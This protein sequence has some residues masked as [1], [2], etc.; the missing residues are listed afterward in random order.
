MPVVEEL[1]D[2]LAG[3]KFFTKLDLRSGYHQIRMAEKDEAKTAFKSHSGHFEFRVMPFGLTC[4]PAT[5]QAAMNSI[6][7]HV[8]RKFVLVF[9]DDILIYSRTLAD[10]IHHLDQVFN[11]LLQNQL[12]VK[13]NKCSFAQPSLEYLGHIIGA[14]GVS[15]DPA[16]IDAVQQW[17]TPLNVKQLRGFLGLAGYYRRFIRNFG[18]I[19]RP[20]TTLLKKNVPYIWTSI[21]DEAFSALKHAL[22]QAPVLAL[23]DFTKEFVL[24]TDACAYGM[25]AVLM[26]Q[27]HP[28]AFLSRALGPKNQ[29]LSTYDKEC[30]AIL[31]GI[32]KW[33]SYLQHRPFTILTDQKS[34]VQLGDHRFNTAMQQKAFFRL[35]GLRYKI[36][37]KKGITNKAA[38][39]LSRRSAL[40]HIHAMSTVQPRWVEIIMEGYQQDPHAKQL[41][42]ELAIQSP[43]NQGFSLTDGI[44][45]F[46]GRIWLGIH[47]AAHQ[48]VLLALHSSGLGG[49]SGV[50]ATYH[51]V[52]QLFAWP[53]LKQDVQNFVQHCRLCQQAKSD[54][55]RTPGLL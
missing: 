39:A 50:L 18:I 47:K 19:C 26:Q 48:A 14:D 10:H 30:V 15:T 11:L 17:P 7:A 41:L 44:I 23:L 1:M 38:D 40:L 35:M 46:H 45:R 27:G 2:E 24:E 31:L 33:K 21:E 32:D 4:A 28:L 13:L 9:V 52:K 51:K 34:L 54:H 8:I 49:H 37:Y 36:V 16:K 55:N 29:S 3:A 42:S 20:L 25:G 22:V 53:K 5:F 43:N 12:F 6:F